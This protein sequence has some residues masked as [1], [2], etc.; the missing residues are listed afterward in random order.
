MADEIA[1]DRNDVSPA[2]GAA[3]DVPVALVTGSSR[4]IGKAIA[5]SLAGAGFGVAVAARSLHSGEIRDHPPTIRHSDL[6]PLSGSLV[7]TA[8]EIESRGRRALCLQM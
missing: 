1:L 8:E 3:S 5:I 2:S 7:E 4:G 6:R